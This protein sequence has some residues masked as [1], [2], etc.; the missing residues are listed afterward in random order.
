MKQATSL[1][2]AKRMAMDSYRKNM[3]QP[4]GPGEVQS[5]PFVDHAYIDDSYETEVQYVVS[6]SYLIYGISDVQE[7]GSLYYFDKE[8][9]R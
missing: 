6:I 8:N 5:Y 9:I 2:Q 7:S 1:E 3:R 4:V